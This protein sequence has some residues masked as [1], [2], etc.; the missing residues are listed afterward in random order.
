MV[1]FNGSRFYCNMCHKNFCT[2]TTYLKERQKAAD[3]P[4]FLEDYF[5]MKPSMNHTKT[6]Q[7][8]SKRPISF[9]VPP[10]LQYTAQ[11]PIT[12]LEKS[13]DRFLCSDKDSICSN[14]ECGGTLI[15][16]NSC[17]VSLYCKGYFIKCKGRLCQHFQIML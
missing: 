17:D 9:D 4:E 7:S 12:Y 6:I 14:S 2:H 8:V 3:Q 13:G 11:S 5:K 15:F 16:G 10:E 1:T